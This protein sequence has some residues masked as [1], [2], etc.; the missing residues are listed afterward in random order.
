[1]ANTKSVVELILQAKVEG[2]K[3]FQQLTDATTKLMQQQQE[4]EKAAGDYDQQLEKL[5][6]TQG[7]LVA[8]SRALVEKGQLVE[9]FKAQATATSQADA[10]AKALIKTASELRA[11]LKE[12]SANDPGRA[13]LAQ[14]FDRASTAAQ[15]AVASFHRQRDSLA[16]LNGQMKAAGLSTANLAKTEAALT[17]EAHRLRTAQKQ[18]ADAIAKTALQADKFKASTHGA[19]T[20]LSRLRGELLRV[21]AAYVSLRGVADAAG[22]VVDAGKAIQTAL[23]RFSVGTGSLEAAR[24]ELEFTRKVANDLSLEF[25]PLIGQYAKLVA[26]AK[27][28]ELE[29]QR[30]RD[31]FLGIAEA[32]RVMQIDADSLAG[33]VKAV[34][35]IISKGKVSAEELRQ[36]LGDRMTGAFQLFAAGLGVSTSRLDEMLKAGELTRDSLVNFGQ[37]LRDRFGVQVPQALKSAAAAQAAYRNELFYLREEA[38]NSGFL[39]AFTESLHDLTDELKSPGFKAGARSFGELL[40][41]LA[42][43]VVFLIKN[44]DSLARLLGAF[45]VYKVVTG[46]GTLKGALLGVATSARAAAGAMG[47]FNKALLVIGAAFAGFEVGKILN[48][49]KV[50]RATAIGAIGN[51]DKVAQT[52]LITWRKIGPTIKATVGEALNAVL[53]QFRSWLLDLADL[54][55]GV[56]KFGDTLASQLRKAAQGFDSSRVNVRKYRDE[57]KRL[58]EEL[59]RRKGIIDA[60]VSDLMDSIIGDPLAG[61]NGST[62]NRNGGPGGGGKKDQ[63]FVVDSG[64]AGLAAAE[65]LQRDALERQQRALEQS[66]SDG[67]VSIKAYFAERQKLQLAA[68]D[69]DIRLKEAELAA[70]RR[71]QQDTAQILADIEI[72]YRNKAAVVADAKREEAQTEQDLANTVADLRT[73]LAAAEGDEREA[74]LDELRRE[75]EATISRLTGLGDSAGVE[76]ARKLFNVEAAKVELQALEAKRQKAL[77]EFQRKLDN[78]ANQESI[79]ALSS[80]QAVDQADTAQADLNATLDG[81]IARSRE[82]LNLY[83]DNTTVAD[84]F[85]QFGQQTQQAKESI[86]GLAD[87]AKLSAKDINQELAQGLTN[88]LSGFIQGTVKAKDA[89]RQ[90]AA[91]FLRFLGEAILKVQILKAVGGAS[92]GGGIGGFLAPL[93]F[94]TA[95]TGGVIGEG[96][97]A[98]KAVPPV[99]FVGAPKYHS[100][101]V[102]GL[103]PSEVPIIAQ[104][105]EEVLTRM[106]PRHR[107]NL[108]KGGKA[109]SPQI[110]NYVLFDRDQLTRELLSSP[111]GVQTMVQV[112]GEN[113]EKFGRR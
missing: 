97:S 14:Q 73:R 61:Q 11:R 105:G 4:A 10:R 83:G 27:G 16:K 113:P 49:F 85:S 57:I 38:A 109:S 31:I 32:A 75:F 9:A 39:D 19:F 79:G 112:V 1:M 28:T 2:E 44:V 12:L 110:R 64:S 88:A 42:K 78:I 106:D 81:L 29:G 69:S 65:K 67:L 104:R 86:K 107:D 21:A 45:T 23:Q 50:V 60:N 96:F 43:V 102:V 56:P 35:Q 40:G 92:G 91:D 84:W 55:E 99:A 76:I 8:V 52:L 46:L 87:N 93:L 74:R 63:G 24:K 54:V 94:G 17:A 80:G 3:T 48:S 103:A 71:Q 82:L 101:G 41:T 95:H 13:K 59:A 20:G 37:A 53:A 62:G 108:A 15:K 66:Y 70:A 5:K 89:L 26:A 58:N 90:F 18:T 72:L 47:L 100:G 98:Y 25:E 111:A 22:G 7:D 30:T 36:Q 51:I 34:E 68:L 33:S 77:D 6:A